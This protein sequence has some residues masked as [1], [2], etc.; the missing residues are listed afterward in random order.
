[1]KNPVWAVMMLGVGAMSRASAADGGK[2]DLAGKFSS[3]LSRGRNKLLKLVSLALYAL[4]AVGSLRAFGADGKPFTF[5]VVADIQY[6]DKDTRDSRQY[7]K[8]LVKV[9]DSVTV[10]NARPLDFVIE[11]GDLVDGYAKDTDRSLRDLDRV[12]PLLQE[13]RAPLYYV[14]GNHCLTGGRTN[15]MAR[16]HLE[17]AW[18]DFT[19][20]AAPG[21]RFVVL[22]G[23][24]AGYG[25]LGPKQEEWLKGVLDRAGKAGERVICFC[26]FPLVQPGGQDQRL[27][28]QGKGIQL[29]NGFPCVVAWFSGHEHRGGYVEA[30]GIHYL[31]FKGMVESV[32]NAYSIVTL[33]SDR[34]RVQGFG[35]EPSRDLALPPQKK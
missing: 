23:N 20:P 15:V 21:W 34:I 12:L 9:Q 19:R 24:E 1:M 27:K 10:F 28:G 2:S 16:L 13:V 35:Q 14:L 30:D 32:S 22:D 29:L 31:T 25:V 17:K 11:L 33:E 4:L 3:T 18:Y 26:H 8:S 5:G 7:R 6:A